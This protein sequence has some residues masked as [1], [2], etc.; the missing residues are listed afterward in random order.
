MESV[1]KYL[2]INNEPVEFPR[3]SIEELFGISEWI[4]QQR[5]SEARQLGA[6][7]KLDKL[8][9]A[10]I[11]LDIRHRKPALSEILALCN[12]PQVACRVIRTSLKKAKVAEDK[13]AALVAG[14]PIP[15]A[16]ELAKMLVLDIQDEKAKPEEPEKKEAEGGE[17]DGSGKPAT[18][19]AEP[20]PAYGS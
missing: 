15:D 5:E 16:I 10:N 8:D 20:A 4:C 6:Q 1:C 9:V 18:T 17:G 12:T 13:H 3:L 11:C 7:D 14:V 2:T 19:S